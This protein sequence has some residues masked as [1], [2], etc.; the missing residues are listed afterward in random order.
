[1]THEWIGRIGVLKERETAEAGEPIR[2]E[3]SL[4]ELDRVKAM[5][6]LTEIVAVARHA[7]N[8]AADGVERLF[9]A[10]FFVK[11]KRDALHLVQVEEEAMAAL[12]GS[13]IQAT[14]AH[15]RSAQTDELERPLA[16]ETTADLLALPASDQLDTA[17]DHRVVRDERLALHRPTHRGRVP[18][19]A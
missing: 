4:L 19:R 12:G 17:T 15:D 6:E 2:G 8:L 13:R 16:R 1:E 14:R 11:P 5:G 10:S 18:V 9:T 7:A 3:L